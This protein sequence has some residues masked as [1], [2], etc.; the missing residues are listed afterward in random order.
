[1][2]NVIRFP[3]YTKLDIDPD[4]VLNGAKGELESVLILGTCQDGEP[5]VAASTSNRAELLLLVKQFEFNLL[6]GYYDD[7]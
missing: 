6:S 4:G 1:M 2:D 5:Y 3:G 7:E